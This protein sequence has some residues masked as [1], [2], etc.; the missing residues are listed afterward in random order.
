MRPR[1]VFKEMNFGYGY[2]TE[3]HYEDRISRQGG[4]VENKLQ[5][6]GVKPPMII[7]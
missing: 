7:K 3:K 1:P 6:I 4:P 2:E 5:D